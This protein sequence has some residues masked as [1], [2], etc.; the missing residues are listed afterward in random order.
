MEDG[1]PWIAAPTIAETGNPW[2]AILITVILIVINGMLASAEIAMMGLSEPKLKPKADSGDKKSRLLLNMK[3][4]P[5]DFLSTIQIGITLAG[6]LSGAFAADSLAKP[7]ILWVASAG[8]QG[9]A[10]SVISG[11]LTFFIT[12]IMTFFMLVFGE[13]V[14]KRI[15]MVRPETTARRVIGLI[16]GLSLFT[17]PLVHLLSLSTNLVLKLIGINASEESS[18]VTEEDIL[19]MMREGQEQGE[20]EEQEIQLLSNV[21]EFSTLSVEDVMIHRTEAEFVHADASINDAIRH[22]GKTGFSKFPVIDGDIDKVI[23]TL[24]LRDIIR[25][26]ADGPDIG[27][28]PV[29]SVMRPP[30]FVFE[31]KPVSEV[32]T[33]LKNSK[34]RLAIVVDEYGGTSGILTMLDI[35]E[36]IVGDIE[37]TEEL[38]RNDDG[39]YLADG[40]MEMEHLCTMLDIPNPEDDLDTLSGFLIRQ[41]GY[42]PSTS[43]HPEIIYCGYT[44]KI[45][46]MDSAIAGAILIKP[47]REEE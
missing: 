31:K 1:S 16:T 47:P 24:Y 34:N 22:A 40:R 12:L 10:L 37:I 19:I 41:L 26:Y 17:K 8:V 35:I 42:V 5:S 3:Q 30:Y 20:I 9:M 6:L 28:E 39:T 32:F 23:G 11:L 44:F 36:E 2:I 38:R 15:A 33:E 13:L 7:L 25:H 43:Q 18:P 46:Q 27:N 45:V 14:P 29:S 4:R 21:F